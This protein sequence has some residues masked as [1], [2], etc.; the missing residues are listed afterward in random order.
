MLEAMNKKAAVAISPLRK[1]TAAKIIG[2]YRLGSR[3]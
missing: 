2:A 1:A 3:F